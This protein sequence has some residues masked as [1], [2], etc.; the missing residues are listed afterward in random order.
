MVQRKGLPSD[1]ETRLLYRCTM[2]TAYI[3]S[4]VGGSSSLIRFKQVGR[5]SCLILEEP[6]SSGN[7]YKNLNIVFLIK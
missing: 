4:K 6:Y 2:G 1:V 7:N 5:S 3:G